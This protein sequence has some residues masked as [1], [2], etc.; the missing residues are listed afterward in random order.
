MTWHLHAR[1]GVWRVVSPL[2]NKPYKSNCLLIA[3]CLYLGP[4]LHGLSAIVAW[5]RSVLIWL[6]DVA[7]CQFSPL[8][9]KPAVFPCYI[10]HLFTIRK[11]LFAYQVIYIYAFILVTYWEYILSWHVFF[12]I[13]IFYIRFVNNIQFPVYY[14]VFIL[15]HLLPV[16]LMTSGR[17]GYSTSELSLDC[18]LAVTAFSH[19]AIQR[20]WDCDRPFPA[21]HFCPECTPGENVGGPSRV[22]WVTREPT[23]RDWRALFIYRKYSDIL[24]CTKFT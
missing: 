13:F 15:M 9:Q 3:A 18:G 6:S 8:S 5:F 22:K 20:S 12:L 4:L 21:G 11:I 19:E 2:L 10:I 16:K 24:V 23:L 14:P 7:D 1:D 17:F